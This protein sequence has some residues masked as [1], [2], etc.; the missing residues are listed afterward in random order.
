MSNTPGRRLIRSPFPVER[1]S[2]AAASPSQEAQDSPDEKRRALADLE[3]QKQPALTLNRPPDQQSPLA[4]LETWKQPALAPGSSPQDRSLFLANAVARYAPVQ[5]NPSLSPALPTPPGPTSARKKRRRAPLSKRRKVALMIALILLLIPSFLIIFELISAFIL[6]NEMQDGMARLQA[7]ESL[8]RGNGAGG[9]AAYFNLQKLQQAQNDIAAAHADFASLSD[10]FDH[11]GTIALA[12]Q[13][14]PTQV[15]TAR[16]LGHLATSGMEVAQQLLKTAQDIAPS[17][18]PALQKGSVSAENAPL[19]PYLTPSS[20][21]EINT[22]L[23]AITPLLGTMVRDAQGVSLASLPLSS[24]QRET[25]ASLLPLL[26]MLTT[27]LSQEHGVRDALGWFLGIDGQRAFLVEPMDRAE[28]RATGGF[29]GQFGDLVINGAHTGPLKLSN[30][31]KYEED[32][33]A[34]GSPPDPTIYPKVIGQSPPKPYADWWPIANFGL[35]DA[36]LSADFPTSARMAMDRYRYE[37]G[38]H[39]DGV[40]MFTPTL[41]EHVLHVTGPISIPAY[42]QTVTEQNLEE[43]L[44]YYQLNNT[45]IRQEE[46]VEHVSDSQLARKLF[47]QRVTQGLISTVTH[48]PLNKMLSLAGEMFQSMKS[49][50]LQIFVTNPQLESLLGKYGSTASFDRSTTHDGFFLV[51]SNL[52]ASKASQYVTTTI[53]DAITLDR[54][55]GATHHLQVTLNYQQKGDVYGFDTYRDYLRIYVPVNSQLLAGN[56]FDQYDSPYCGDAQSGYRLC[57]SDVY[58]DGSL[59]CVPPVTIGYA[60]SYLRDPY[61]GKD[62][63]LDRTGPPPNQQSDEAGR[64][65]FGGWV[66]IPKNCVAKVTLS[67]YVPPLSKQAYSL[68]LQAQAGVDAPLDLT[69]HPFA[70]VCSPNQ[71]KALR[72]SREMG[73]EDIFLT[74]KQQGTMCSLAAQ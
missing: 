4:D 41:I 40:I 69:I 28:L 65:M 62:H 5:P 12:S 56:G 15:E 59:V 64:A 19:K 60:T 14:L 66:V 20:Y 45:G 16:A 6:Y 8:F 68:L 67:W 50:D 43:L 30:I 29:T 44:H 49:K 7:V 53:Q 54:R 17:V 42:K 1:P 21:Q 37:F 61:A 32:H 22:T 39:V 9:L 55:G 70:G 31:G 35:R 11:E 71:G 52:S 74:L 72:F 48:L 23:D 46:I 25:I 47:T 3:T 36:N 73:G 13:F 10:A 2:P 26:P 58:G 51:Q 18:A 63:P 24:K 27:A 57:Q 34:E 33:T 38:K